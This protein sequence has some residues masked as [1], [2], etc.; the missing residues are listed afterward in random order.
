MLMVGVVS[1]T[2]F[3]AVIL[4]TLQVPPEAILHSGLREVIL[5]FEG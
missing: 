2:A 3:V 5:V 4:A 1:Y